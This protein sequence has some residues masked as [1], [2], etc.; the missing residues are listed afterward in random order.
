[1]NNNSIEQIIK[2]SLENSITYDD[3]RRLVHQYVL[4][5][6]TSGNDKTEAL[7]EYTALN[8]RRMKRWDKT[9]K[10]SEEDKNRIQDFNGNVTWLVI[11]E[12]W[13]G[14]AAH[15]IP[16]L[17]KIAEFSETIDLKLVFR[18]ENEALMDK[19]LTNGGKAIAKLIMI[20]N[21]T[22][23]V[24]GTFGPRPTEATNMV[25]D[26][27]AKHG[28]LTPEFKEQL[29]LW[30]NKDKGRNVVADIMELLGV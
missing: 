28:A 29:Q 22:G 10:I 21:D 20:N 14:D 25:V 24:L 12:S 11:T 5:N 8:E 27:K 30:Y 23:N 1:M 16:V 2:N 26:Y 7:A 9:L 19:F 4:E 15:V 18:D 17:N 13:C 6:S 3:Y